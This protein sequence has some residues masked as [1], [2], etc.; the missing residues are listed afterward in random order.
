M[1]D[2]AIFIS[3]RVA[4]AQVEAR[5]LFTD[6]ANYFGEHVAFL[7][8][9]RL[10]A[11][12][13]WPEELEDNVQKA[14]VLLVLIKNKT[15]WL[16][17]DEEGKRR[18]DQANDWVRLEIEKAFARKIK[19]IPI[20]ID[21][22][23]LPSMGALPLSLQDLYRKQGSKISTEKWD[24][25]VAALFADLQETIPRIQSAFTDALVRPLSEYPL[26]GN[27]PDL[28]DYHPAP[29]LGL[30]FFSHTA[31]SLFFGRTREILEFF[32]LVERSDVQLISLFGY[33]GVG[34]SS[35]LAAGILPRLEAK[36]Q[37]YYERR[38]ITEGLGKQLTRLRQLPKTAG[39]PPVYILDQV[40]EIFTDLLP[41]EREDFVQ[42]LRTAVREEPE[43]TIV[44]GFRSDFQLEIS[45]L[46]ARVNCRREN[47]PLRSLG[48][49]ALIESIEGVW[50]DPSLKDRYH[51]EIEKGFAD[52]VARDL[53]HTESGGAAA[54]LQNRLLRLYDQGRMH[55]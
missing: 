40:E 38:K 31:A 23:T 15:R 10:E 17:V 24:S 42:S 16:G 43:A 28:L 1:P 19:I 48:Q 55:R 36:W 7:D 9:K 29:F 14:K 32:N 44:L 47:L 3:Y 49:A 21:D 52:F 35:L 8:K 45:D 22:A 5:L 6:L 12:M 51:L 13:D 37:P 2:P 11:G 26:P 18:I 33:S 27:S 39:K 34:K 20:L 30:V 41:D 54:I 50:R 53:L 25:D 4:D 46:L